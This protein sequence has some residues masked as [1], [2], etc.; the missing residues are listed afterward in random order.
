MKIIFIHGYTASSKADWYPTI[1]EQLDK[2]SIPYAVPDLPGDRN[3]H[4]DRWLPVIHREFIKS[5]EPV[6]LVGHSLGTRAALLYLEKYPVHVHGLILIAPLAN[7]LENADRRDGEAYPDFFLHKVDMEKI[8]AR[9]PIRIVMHSTD[10]DSIPYEQ[11]VE[12]AGDLDAK[13]MTYHDRGHF[14]ARENHAYV[15]EVLQNVLK[16]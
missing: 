5:R 16:T 7:R 12:L 11:G 14:F 2:L 9:A 1:A 6:I 15:L 4:A 8:K 3:P 13:L 10:D